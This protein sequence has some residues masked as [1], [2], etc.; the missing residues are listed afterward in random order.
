M[1]EFGR[2]CECDANNTR[3]SCCRFRLNWASLSSLQKERYI[4]AVLTVSSSPAY[5]PLYEELLARYQESFETMAQSTTP[6]TT[7]FI[8]WHRYF[9]LEYEDLLRLVDRDI[10]IPYWDWSV[11]TTDPYSSPVFD[12]ET[13][14]GDQSDPDTNCVTT[15]PF[16]EEGGFRVTTPNGS[17]SCL[18]REYGDFNF[19]NR[20]ILFMSLQLGA[21]MFDEFHRI[22]QL[23]IS[24]N[25]RCFVGGEICSTNAASDPL[26]LLHL[27]RLDLHVQQWQDKD[28]S[29]SVVQLSSKGDV[30][31]NSL[32]SSLLVS[33]F[34]F[35]EELPFETCVRYSPLDPVVA[36]GELREGGEIRCAPENRLNEAAASL[37]EDDRLYLTRTCTNG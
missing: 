1:D 28:R 25:I 2:I 36:R 32:D 23:F 15:G 31:V 24:L 27:A 35:N 6:E 22:L 13:G 8:P 11:L 33:N 14:F 4:S 29:N 9:L 7:Q 3:H 26:F 19:F 20:D 16:R 37:S 34:C 21:D 5:R 12:S 17:M 30:L 18:R 10:T